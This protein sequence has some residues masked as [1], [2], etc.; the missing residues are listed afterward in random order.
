MEKVLRTPDATRKGDKYAE[1][2]RVVLCT[3][4]GFEGF[5]DANHDRENKNFSCRRYSK[6]DIRDSVA[7]HGFEIRMF[8]RSI[9][10]N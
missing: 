4:V 10:N 7:L 1:S 3:L 6:G 8:S 9:K 5:Q 2:F